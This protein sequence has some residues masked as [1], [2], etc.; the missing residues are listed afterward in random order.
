M[1]NA[2]AEVRKSTSETWVARY[3][4]YKSGQPMTSYFKRALSAREADRCENAREP[5]CVCRCNG[6]AHGRGSVNVGDFDTMTKDAIAILHKAFEALPKD[7]PHHLPTVIEEKEQARERKDHRRHHNYPWQGTF[8]R[9]GLV[10][11]EW[12]ARVE[13]CYICVAEEKPTRTD[14]NAA[15]PEP[16]AV[17]A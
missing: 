4:F 17:E 6:A 13:P 7:D 9:A 11:G 16:E 10:D 8:Y 5:K 1:R 15:H 12:V 3:E 2:C 14:W